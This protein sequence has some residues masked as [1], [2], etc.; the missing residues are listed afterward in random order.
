MTATIETL[1]RPA[2]RIEGYIDAIDGN[3][4]YGWAWDR[5]NPQDRLGVE[6]MLD[7]R[8]VIAATADRPRKDLAANGIGDG[9][10]AF[11]VVLDEPLADTMTETLAIAVAS[12]TTRQ[13]VTLKTRE[14][15]DEAALLRRVAG[16]VDALAQG[17]RWIGATLR[18]TRSHNPDIDPG[19]LDKAL[20]EIRA[21]Q[22]ALQAQT[23]G[24]EVFLLR[25]ETLMRDL[26]EKA[27]SRAER[28]G[29]G[30]LGRL[31]GI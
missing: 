11:E 22:M 31:L 9:A 14:P 12:P 1:E 24:I 8:V 18:D 20:D 17:Q 19:R 3:R 29:G 30:W 28:R 21:A 10:H 5:L 6:L 25:F 23:A 4:V 26:S 27:G 15:E 2:S 7:G 16:T 13:R